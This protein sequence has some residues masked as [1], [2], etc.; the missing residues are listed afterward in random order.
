M[1]QALMFE[2]PQSQARALA[3]ALDHAASWYA[4]R[5]AHARR[6][7]GS[8]FRG[9]RPT[10]RR[11]LSSELA[12]RISGEAC[13]RTEQPLL[14]CWLPAGPPCGD[15]RDRQWPRAGCDLCNQ[16]PSAS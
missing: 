14:R 6:V 2:A 16:T 1:G 15:L 11:Q 13:W 8:D 4:R 3:S 5:V 10:V 7:A 12:L 9:S